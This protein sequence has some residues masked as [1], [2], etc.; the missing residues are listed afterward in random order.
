MLDKDNIISTNV[1]EAV[2][3]IPTYKKDYRKCTLMCSLCTA[4]AYKEQLCTATDQQIAN[5]EIAVYLLGCIQ[6]S[7]KNHRRHF[8]TNLHRRRCN[9]WHMI[10]F[11]H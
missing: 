2:E 5:I 7:Y 4:T 6:C 9:N 10:S 3:K 8:K 1:S 11:I